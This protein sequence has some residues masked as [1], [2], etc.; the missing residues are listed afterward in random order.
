LPANVRSRRFLPFVCL[1]LL[2]TLQPLPA[3]TTNLPPIPLTA[4]KTWAYQIQ[5]V[6][7]A[8]AV[9]ALAQ[10]RYDLLVV[11]PSRTDWSSPENRRF[12]TP[13]MVRRLQAA[14]AGDGTHRRLVLAYLDIGE[15]ETWRWYWT[16]PKDWT[17]GRPRPA[18]LPAFIIHPDPDGWSGDFPVVFW[19]PVWQDILLT[20]DR[21]PPAPDRTYRSLMDEVLQSGFDGVYL[22]WVE[23]Y[24]D[25]AVKSAARTAGVDPAREMIR[26]LGAIRDYGRQRNP[27]FVVIQQNAAD[28]LTGHPELLNVIDAIG[29]EDVW[30]SGAAD[31]DWNNPKGHDQRTSAGQTRETLQLLQPFRA[32]GKPVFTVDY[33]VPDAPATYRRA[34]AAGFVPY[35][36]RVSLSRL[37]T[38]PPPELATP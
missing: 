20:G 1:S 15:A 25:P 33:T 18:G 8:G 17:K 23:A 6:P 22:D 32:A 10:S 30:Y 11:E 36:T 24:D 31:S 35:C 37:T 3:Q 19:N 12:D 34:R 16:W 29:Q 26:L 13:G 2:V 14:P 21:T 27:A 28:L 7:T 5:D 9:D 4:V 38:T